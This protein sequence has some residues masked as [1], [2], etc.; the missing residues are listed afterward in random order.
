M[1]SQ[2]MSDELTK[3][4]SDAHTVIDSVIAEGFQDRLV[5]GKQ[6]K[7]LSFVFL[8]PRIG[9]VQ[10]SKQFD[11]R[12][13]AV[14]TELFHRAWRGT[15][16]L[17]KKMRPSV[18]TES[19]NKAIQALYEHLLKKYK[20]MFDSFTTGEWSKL[21]SNRLSIFSLGEKLPTEGLILCRYSYCEEDQ[22]KIGMMMS[23]HLLHTNLITGESLKIELIDNSVTALYVKDQK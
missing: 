14:N 10:V 21:L 3:S 8:V 16:D 7:T 11:E 4:L 1:A 20:I 19:K 17:I 6:I 9:E 22:N 12:V 13:A 2:S 15:M 23:A 18:F 5:N